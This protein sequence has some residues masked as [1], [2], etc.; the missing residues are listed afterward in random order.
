MSV[1][2]GTMWQMICKWREISNAQILGPCTHYV[3]KSYGECAT[4]AE[5]QWKRLRELAEVWQVWQ[6][7]SMI[8]AE[9]IAYGKCADQLL[10]ILG[11]PDAKESGRR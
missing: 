10:A 8:N 5:A 7:Q 4:E 11:T 3:T 9:A 6:R 2:P 1:L